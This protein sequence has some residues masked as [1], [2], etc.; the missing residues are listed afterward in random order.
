ML[1]CVAL[2]G[3]EDCSRLQQT[4]RQ[5]SPWHQRPLP[6]STYP[7][8]R[9][10]H[11]CLPRATRAASSA[12]FNGPLLALASASWS[13]ESPHNTQ[14]SKGGARDHLR[15]ETPALACAAAPNVSRRVVAHVCESGA[16]LVLVV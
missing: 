15:A 9:S 2:L 6:A 13:M 4:P 5:R 8:Q 10:T 14:L 3:L 7:S 1:P 11:R 16:T 12:A